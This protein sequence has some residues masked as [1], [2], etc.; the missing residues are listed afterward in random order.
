MAIIHSLNDNRLKVFRLG[1]GLIL[2]QNGPGMGQ[3]RP[4]LDLELSHAGPM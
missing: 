1:M 2:A 4:V 3:G